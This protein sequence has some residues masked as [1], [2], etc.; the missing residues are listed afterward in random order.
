MLNQLVDVGL[1]VGAGLINDAIG[2]AI[3]DCVHS[4]VP[5][6]SFF[7]VGCVVTT[8]TTVTRVTHVTTEINLNND[9]ETIGL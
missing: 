3:Q 9:D 2:A 1:A 5:F 6:R 7:V 4:D 8:S